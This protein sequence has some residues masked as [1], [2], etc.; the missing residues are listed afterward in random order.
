MSQFVEVGELLSSLKLYPYM[1]RGTAG[2]VD[3]LAIVG[4]YE[5]RSENTTNLPTGAYYYGI[6]EIFGGGSFLVQRYTPH[7]NYSGKFGEYNR[8]KF[9]GVWTDWRFIPYQ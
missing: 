5:T 8:V 6:L 4:Y 3:D 2:N 9:Q 1:Y 7:A